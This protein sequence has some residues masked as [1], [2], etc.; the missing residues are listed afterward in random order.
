[1]E[2][3]DLPE[4][5]RRKEVVVELLDDERDYGDDDRGSRTSRRQRDGDGN[6]PCAD[7]AHERHERR[8]EGEHHDRQDEGATRHGQGSPYDESLNR[9]KGLQSPAR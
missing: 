2:V 4:D 6:D 3:K 9:T 7:G 5:D 8:H 1:M